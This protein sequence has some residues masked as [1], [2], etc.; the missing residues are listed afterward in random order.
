MLSDLDPP[1]SARTGKAKGSEKTTYDPIGRKRV[2]TWFSHMPLYGE[3]GFEKT[4]TGKKGQ[5]MGTLK[6]HHATR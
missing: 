2:P 3:I 1:V 6:K 5:G 4:D